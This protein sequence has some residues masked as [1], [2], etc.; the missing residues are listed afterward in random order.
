[1]SKPTKYSFSEGQICSNKL[2]H[3]C[4]ILDCTFYTSI[5]VRAIGGVYDYTFNICSRDLNE[6]RWHHK[7][8]PTTYGRGFVG[9]GDIKCTG[10]IKELWK[11]IFNRCYDENYLK[12]HPTYIGCEVYPAWYDYQVFAKD[13]KSKFGYDLKDINGKC[14]SLDK[15]IISQGSLV[16]SNETTVFVP[17]YIN[18]FFRDLSKK[19]YHY[20]RGRF[21]TPIKSYI[22]EEEA[23]N[24]VIEYQ[25]NKAKF[26]IETYSGKVDDRVIEQVSKYLI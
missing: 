13:I 4:I 11:G 18:T 2:G 25:S 16:Y 21:R 23:I 15:E 20:D 3:S 7:T 12:K 6:G 8:I 24:G 14:Y 19:S 22:T 26:I 9:Y 1:M 17:Q 5:S 10:K